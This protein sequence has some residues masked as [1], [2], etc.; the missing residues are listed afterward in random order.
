MP[1]RVREA[2]S[3]GR[4]RSPV[5]AQRVIGG[6]FDQ[7]NGDA[8]RVLDPHLSQSP[9]LVYRLTQDPN[10]GRC[11]PHMLGIDIPYLEPHHHRVP[12]TSG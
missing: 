5:A 4:R 9:R 11:Q 3:A 7:D 2:G 10:A 6:N 8:V 1:R 12:G